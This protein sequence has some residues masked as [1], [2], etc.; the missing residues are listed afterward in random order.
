[1][2]GTSASINRY[3]LLK[4]KAKLA[5]DHQ[6]SSSVSE[7]TTQEDITLN[8]DLLLKAEPLRSFDVKA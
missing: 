3:L 5:P 1:M 6:G 2:P 4:D 7:R 8:R